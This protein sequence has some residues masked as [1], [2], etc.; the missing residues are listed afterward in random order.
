MSFAVWLT[1]LSGSGKSAIARELVAQ[2]H[3]RGIDAALLESDVMRTQLT[4]FAGYA[5]Q[6][7]DF[8]YAALA[9]LGLSE[10]LKV[11]FGR[12]PRLAA[13]IRTARGVATL[14]LAARGAALGL[15]PSAAHAI[16]GSLLPFLR[17]LRLLTVL[18]QV[19]DIAHDETPSKHVCGP[20]GYSFGP[21]CR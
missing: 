5:P 6:E 18:I 8:F 11:T 1:G 16:G 15:G 3:A 17:A 21:S 12:S 13:M 4:P 2:L 10:V 7:R 14:C 9:Q 19:H 20:L